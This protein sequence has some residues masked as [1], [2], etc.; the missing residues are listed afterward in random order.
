MAL[1]VTFGTETAATGGQLDQNFSAVGVLTTI[2]CVVSG[3]NALTLAPQTNTPTISAYANYL[4]VSGI[5]VATSTGTMTAQVAALP[6]L[7][8]YIDTPSGPVAAGSGNLVA[9]N[10]FE[11]VF[12]S[13]L[14]SGSGGFH[15]ITSGLAVGA[16]VSGSPTTGHIAAWTGTSSIGDGG[17][18][19]RLVTLFFTSSGTFTTPANT[20]ATTGFEIIQLGAGG[21]SYVNA[22]GP[23]GSGGSG[24]VIYC[25]ATGL[26]A[27]SA[28]AITIG[29]AGTN[30]TT[31]ATDGTA[32]TVVLTTTSGTA[33]LQA[34]GG[35]HGTSGLGGNGGVPLV[36][37]T[38]T[39]LSLLQVYGAA[40]IVGDA[41]QI[42]IMGG[43]SIF[44]GSTNWG[45]GNTYGSGSYA[46]SGSGGIVGAG[47]VIVRYVI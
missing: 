12:D 10:E 15:L 4:R 17:A 26:P 21:G 22:S 47:L 2:P 45:G 14:N 46:A 41:T 37:G 3:T 44:G 35:S 11:L 42:N 33:T 39:G 19:P 25:Y 24:A 28:N 6:I 9:G 40:G 7:P 34:G 27:S 8:V 29:A 36:T 20:I 18:I 5:A 32:T 43:V 31:T 13:A 1:P 38:T 23:L 16:Q 30:S